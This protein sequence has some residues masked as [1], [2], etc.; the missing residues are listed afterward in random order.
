MKLFFSRQAT[1]QPLLA[2]TTPKVLNAMNQ[3]LWL[4]M[5]DALETIKQDPALKTLIITGEGR[6]FSTRADLKKSDKKNVEATFAHVL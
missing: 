6:A 4:E 3:Q 1:P 5:M 2:W